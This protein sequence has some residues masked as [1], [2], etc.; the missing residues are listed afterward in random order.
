[1]SACPVISDSGR[2]QAALFQDEGSANADHELSVTRD[3]LR[4]RRRIAAYSPGW[5]LSPDGLVTLG[6]W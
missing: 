2:R 1:M 5:A 3:V 4:A 6:S